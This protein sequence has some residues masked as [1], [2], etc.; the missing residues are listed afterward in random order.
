MKRLIQITILSL[1]LGALL[2]IFHPL[3]AQES[4]QSSNSPLNRSLNAA[5]NDTPIG[6][7]HTLYKTYVNYSNAAVA[8]GGAGFQPLD[9]PTTVLCPVG[10]GACLIAA[11]QNV[12][13]GD[14]KKGN[15]WAICTQVDGVFMSTPFC[16]YQGFTNNNGTEYF[17]HTGSFAQHMDGVAVGSHTVQTFVYSATG[18]TKSIYT[19]I[20]RVYILQVQ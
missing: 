11:E 10:G 8:V 6:G 7:A 12:Q 14:N 18:L 13:I 16:P 5:G 20:Y 3:S 4:A 15:T 9:D 1:T 2:G 17:Y 19:I